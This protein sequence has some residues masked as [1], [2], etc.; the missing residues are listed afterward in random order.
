MFEDVMKNIRSILH[1]T[2]GIMLENDYDAIMVKELSDSNILKEN[3]PAESSTNQTHIAITGKVNFD[4]FP[5]V[6]I[7]HYNNSKNSEQE[8]KSFYILQVPFIINKQNAYYADKQTKLL[9]LNNDQLIAKGSIKISRPDSAQMELGN[10]SQ[11]DQNF[12]LFRKLF[13]EHDFLIMLKIANKVEY[14]AFCIKSDDAQKYNLSSVTKFNP[15]RKQSTIVDIFTVNSEL[16]RD[17][18]DK[19]SVYCEGGFNRILYGPPG[20]GKSYKI[21]NIINNHGINNYIDGLDHPNV[22][23]TTLHPEFSYSDFVG[24]IMPIVKKNGGKTDIIY[25]FK[26]KIFTEALKFALSD[27]NV[28]VFLI[29]E[30]MSRANIA[31]VFGDIFQLLD[32][33]VYGNSE[34]K[35]NNDLIAE[36]IFDDSNKKIFI[37]SNLYIIGTMNTSD[38]NVYVMDTAMKRRFELEYISATDYIREES[39]EYK[40]NYIFSIQ[41]NEEDIE[42]VITFDWITL[43]KSLNK[44]IVTKEEKGGLSLTEDKQI[45]QFFIKFKKANENIS[46]KEAEDYNFNQIKG[47]LIQYLWND[48]QKHSYS[49]HSI[50][51]E[52]IESFGDLYNLIC[53]KKMIFS[54]NFMEFYNSSRGF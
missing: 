33:D 43:I 26:P 4:F 35:I 46:I 45:G 38:Q 39:G 17:E 1:D 29:L 34:Y 51:L 22:F 9:F 15:K 30:E 13:F 42:S 10:T 14:E 25:D 49:P 11:S 23:R 24:Q 48:V 6:N 5:Y 27:L 18:N 44:F 7:W 19:Y 16:L 31:A 52:D 40:N 20:T 36:Y 2:A 50:F 37:P 21:K 54:S 8:M 41:E 53:D 28:P 32:R 3:R 12:R 47:K